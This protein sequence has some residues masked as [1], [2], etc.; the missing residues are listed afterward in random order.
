MP[1]PSCG[2]ELASGATECP[3]C[4]V[5]LAKHEQ[6]QIEIERRCDMLAP[7][8]NARHLV[9]SQR[10][11]DRFGI[12]D[13]NG[14]L[15]LLAAG[16]S[17]WFTQILLANSRP[18]DLRLTGPSSSEVLFTLCKPL[19]LVDD[20]IEVRDGASVRVGV[21]ESSA[22]IPLRKYALRDARGTLLYEI[23]GAFWRPWTFP[24]TRS[25]AEVG[26]I[27]KDGDFHVRF[28]ERASVEERVLLLAAV[29]LIEMIHFEPTGI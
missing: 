24:V 18:F 16:E 4:R 19:R 26:E 9:V 28:P 21:V 25:G 2:R 10:R 15:V 27:R 5:V 22:P 6:R 11:E 13:E 1:C 7:L 12:F 17:G 14:R 29:F 20:L 8:A 3:F 23:T